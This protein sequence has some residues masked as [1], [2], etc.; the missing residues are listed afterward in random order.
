MCLCGGLCVCVGGGGWWWWLQSHVYH[1]EVFDKKAWLQVAWF[2]SRFFL[3][4]KFISYLISPHL[5]LTV[6][7]AN[8]N[9]LTMKTLDEMYMFKVT[10]CQLA[11]WGPPML[12]M[13]HE[14]IIISKC[15]RTYLTLDYGHWSLHT[16]WEANRRFHA[17]CI[18]I[19]ERQ[20]AP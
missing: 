17:R 15:L 9:S 16:D 2:W 19:G 7:T 6:L 12:K 4:D 14:I 8:K 10:I 20:I 11:W 13:C 5:K 1:F 3:F 18:I